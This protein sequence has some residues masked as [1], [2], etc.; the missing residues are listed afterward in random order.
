MLQSSNEEIQYNSIC[1]LWRVTDMELLNKDSLKGT[2]KYI[3]DKKIYDKIYSLIPSRNSWISSAAIRY[4]NKFDYNREK[5][6]YD[7]LNNNDSSVNVQLAIWTC[8]NSRGKDELADS[9][10]LLRKVKFCFQ[11]PSWLIQQ[12][13]YDYITPSGAPYLENDLMQSYYTAKEQYKKLLIIYALNKHLCDTVF[14]FLTREFHITADTLLQQLILSYLPNGINRQQVLQ[15]YAQHKK[16]TALTLKNVVDLQLKNNLYPSLVLIALK[17]G[18]DPAEIQV[19]SN[20]EATGPL[21]YYYLFE[22]KYHYENSDS[23]KPETNAL[24]KKIEQ[25]LL[26]DSKFK[27]SWLNYEQTHIRYSL[28]EQLIAAHRQLTAKYAEDMRSLFNKHGIDS[29]AYQDFLIP[30]E[31]SASGLYKKKFSHKLTE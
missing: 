22:N 8:W 6:M 28:P 23:A 26:A 27:S 2:P 13:A 15:W 18:W 11:H 17:Q 5:F 16:E 10:L 20:D 1:N 25:Q 29:S 9:A 12:C 4:I 19:Y 31:N 14:N 7:I 30:L 24:Y 3:L 21:L